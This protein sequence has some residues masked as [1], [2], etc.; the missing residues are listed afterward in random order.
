LVA[1]TLARLVGAELLA[2]VGPSGSGKSSLVRAG[3]LSAL[4]A[5]TLPGSERWWQVV[6]TPG[7]RP[8]EVL[9]RA[10]ADLPSEGR[11]LLVVD[12]LEELFTLAVASQRQAFVDR[13]VEE[14]RSPYADVVAVVTLRSDYYGHCAD[15]PD[16]AKLVQATTVL[17]GALR[18]EE[19]ARAV[20]VPAELAGLEVEP[21]VTQ[22]ILADAGDQPGALP[23]VSTALLALWEHRAGRRLTLAGYAQTGGVRGAVARLAD[24]VY[25]GFDPHQQAIAR[26]IF[27]RLTEPGDG[28]DDVRRRAHRSELGDDE[29]TNKVLSALVAR[30]LLITDEHMVEVAHEALLREWPRLRG[31]LE[32]DREGRRLHRQ[33]A[34][35]AS[36]WVAHDRDPEQL[37]RGARLAAA[38]DWAKGHDP[39]LN[40]HE[41]EFLAASTHQHERQLRRARR[42]TAVLASMLVIVLV[43]GVLALAQRSTARRNQVIAAAR[44]LAAQATART[45]SQSDL[46]LLLAVEASRSQDSVETRGGLLTALGQNARLTGF[47]QGFG[48]DLYAFGVA[49]DGSTVAAGSRDGSLRFGDL[50]SGT[51][52]TPPRSKPMAAC[53]A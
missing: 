45:G 21:G 42:T 34:Q 15:Y 13:L 24:G 12:Q 5:G 49:A 11:T 2:V 43:A 53:S 25:D 23:L 20:E 31:W 46:A 52:R 33:L 16:L 8:A 32:E 10:L 17:V 50:G 35:A 38:L 41:R 6:L 4:A 22:A 1:E 37:Y 47:K 44:G 51:L 9:D 30:R 27:L 7:E 18:P 29:A 14:L 39:D 48:N 26:A 36:Q 19:L 40:Q 3:L 28:G